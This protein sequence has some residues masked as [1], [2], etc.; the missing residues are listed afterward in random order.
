VAQ[1]SSSSA[2]S[3]ADH[4]TF[5]PAGGTGHVGRNV[6]RRR[7]SRS[8]D[9]L[10]AYAFVLPLVALEIVF[11]AV[12]LAMGL[13]YSLY[14]VDY[15]ELT[16][17][18]GLGNYLRVLTSP[19]V[20]SA[21]AA[22][23]VFSIASLALTLTVGMGL[24]LHLERDTRWSIAVRAVALIPYVIS[25]LVGSLLLRW[26]FSRDGALME[27][28]LGPLGL[29]DL[30]ILADPNA[31][32]AALVFNAVWR[33]SA[34][35]MILLLSGLKSIPPQIYAAAR[36]DGAGSVY[37][38]RRI[39]LPLM[40]VPILITLVRLLIH[41]VNVLTF[42]LILTGG[43]PNNATQTLGL[44]LYRLGFVEFRLG[45]ANALAFL[46][47]LFNLVLIACNLALFRQRRRP[48]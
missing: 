6:L 10:R 46:V 30:T 9:G 3:L 4:K 44:A 21:F 1:A 23:A 29:G 41:F 22:T 12:P 32:M 45:E 39:T 27:A 2:R 25:M 7:R 18:R 15:F 5:A 28:A 48:A 19:M 16:E 20:L 38:F 34:F 31:A 11:V 17:F 8:P 14:R 40:R 26:I 13:Y 37:Q 24:A 36:V 33:D 43:G 35:A 47:F 42:A